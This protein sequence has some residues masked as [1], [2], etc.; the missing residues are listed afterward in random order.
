MVH[1]ARVNFSKAWTSP[2][3]PEPRVKLPVVT[4]RHPSE[5]KRVPPPPREFPARSVREVDY[6]KKPWQPDPET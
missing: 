4:V 6:P 3:K 5:I 2:L 1:S